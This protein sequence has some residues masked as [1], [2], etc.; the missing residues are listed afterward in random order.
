M[1]EMILGGIG[2]GKLALFNSPLEVG[3]R[4]L[5]ILNYV[6]PKSIDTQ[7][8]VYYSYLSLHTGDFSEKFN[9]LHP[10]IPYRSCQI[11]IQRE[12]VQEGIR[13]LMSKG[14]IVTDYRESGINYSAHKNASVFINYFQSEYS[15]QLTNRIKLVLEWFE[16]MT[17]KQLDV[18]ITKNLTKWGSEFVDEVHHV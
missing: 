6:Y 16:E 17:D 10:P 11:V 1:K 9:S 8:L 3:L 18:Y 5:F 13:L 12:I 7:R 15:L 2:M 4:V 14:L